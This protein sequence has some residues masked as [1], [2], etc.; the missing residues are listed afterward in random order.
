M[1]SP[2]AFI[3]QNPVAAAFAYQLVGITVIK[4]SLQQNKARQPSQENV[5]IEPDYTSPWAPEAEFVK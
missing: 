5:T 4:L 2:C 3:L 1:M